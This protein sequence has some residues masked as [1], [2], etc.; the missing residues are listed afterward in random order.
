MQQKNITN[1]KI[2]FQRVTKKDVDK[3]LEI[4]SKVMNSKTYSGISDKKEALNEFRNNVIYFIKSGNKVIGTTEYELKNKNK[5]YL[6]GTAI[7]PDYQNNGIGRLAMEFRLKK[8]KK[9]KTIE[10]VTHPENNRMLT[11]LLKSG[12]KIKSWKDNYFGDGEPRLFL[13]KN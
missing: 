13:V 7:D 2:T 8:L 6:S 5:A 10:V 3:Y 11:L 1:N 4:E 9:M 12:F